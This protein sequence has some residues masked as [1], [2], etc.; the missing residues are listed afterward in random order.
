MVSLSVSGTSNN[1]PLNKGQV[2]FSSML[3]PLRRG[4]ISLH[5]GKK[6]YVPCREAPLYK[7]QR[8]VFLVERLHCIK[9]KGPC[10]L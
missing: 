10:S 5:Q 1:Q 9:D 2:V 7:G 3:L 4:T 8:T 6:D